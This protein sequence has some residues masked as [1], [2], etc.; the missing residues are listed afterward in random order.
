M[1]YWTHTLVFL[2]LIT[3][4]VPL[5]AREKLVIIQAVSKSARSFAIREGQAQGVAKNQSSLFTTNDAGVIAIAKEVGRHFSVWELRADQGTVP[6]SKGQEVIYSNSPLSVW[7]DIPKH[8]LDHYLK[9]QE[10]LAFRPSQQ[11]IARG[12]YSYAL[13]QS[14][15]QTDRDRYVGRSGVQASAFWAERFR[16]RWEYAGGLRF[17]QERA[18]FQ[19]PAISTI[20]QR[21]L[22][23]AEGSYHFRQLAPA[24][25]HFYLGAG[26]GLGLSFTAI[27]EWAS[28]GATLALPIVK[29]G[30]IERLSYRYSLVLEA[31][32]ESISTNESFADSRQQASH[33]VNGTVGVGLRF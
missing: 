27:D 22:L 18:T 2:A 6:F 7:I 1:K 31:S 11:W 4:A 19:N 32:F 20:T 16:P 3:F 14:I 28:S 30:Y 15:S 8:Q 9:I 25:G 17:D 29:V 13:G 33:A 26:L 5:A 12:H 21:I 10:D 24:Q 23:A